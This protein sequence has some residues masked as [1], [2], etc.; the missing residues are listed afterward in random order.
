M[1]GHF[2]FV[3][4]S[5]FI[6]LRTSAVYK[7]T[8]TVPVFFFECML[9]KILLCIAMSILSTSVAV[10]QQDF[11]SLSLFCSSNAMNVDWLMCGSEALSCKR[12]YIVHFVD[13]K[14][15]E[16]FSLLSMSCRSQ[17]RRN[18]FSRCIRCHSKH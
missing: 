18:L 9:R 15:M 2:F 12:R 17:K 5:R 11:L 7:S 4:T 10:N 14:S 16:D 1:C 13:V 8:F 6:L 3:S